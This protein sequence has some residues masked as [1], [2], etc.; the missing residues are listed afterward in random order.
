MSYRLDKPYTTEQRADFV[1]EYNA[2]QGL[3]I[4]ETEVALF[5]LEKNEIMVDG[6]PIVDPDYEEK[7]KQKEQERVKMLSC[8]K[9][10]FAL[11][12]EELGKSYK[13][14]LKP[15]I[16]SNDRASL[17]WDLCERLYRFNPLLDQMALGLG[18]TSQ[19]LDMLFKVA[20]GENTVEDLKS[21]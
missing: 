7:Q 19:Q 12:L 2:I 13:N 3:I 1:S 4:E 20:N 11:L 21:V 16:E 14:T 15:L 8:T 9:R 10:D 17:E 5:A 6:E 18:I